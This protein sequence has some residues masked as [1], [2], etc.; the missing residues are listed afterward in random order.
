MTSTIAKPTADL[1]ALRGLFECLTKESEDKDLMD[2]TDLMSWATARFNL[3]TD[4]VKL[5]AVTDQ[6][7][8]EAVKGA[9]VT[10]AADKA[11]ADDAVVAAKAGKTAADASGDADAMT[12]AVKAVK[13]AEENQAAMV[14]DTDTKGRVTFDVFKRT[15]CDPNSEMRKIILA[16]GEEEDEPLV[17]AMHYHFQSVIHGFKSRFMNAPQFS[18]VGGR[19][20]KAVETVWG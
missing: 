20:A 14:Y 16:A 1:Q 4:K 6:S 13:D 15:M 5:D 9:L 17:A 18:M 8:Q 19:C 10:A 2:G 11:A 7:C 12:A 3:V